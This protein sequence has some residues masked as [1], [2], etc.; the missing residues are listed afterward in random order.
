M[1]KLSEELVCIKKK[2]NYII[3]W[4]STWKCNRTRK[5]IKCYIAGTIL[6]QTI[7]LSK[8]ILILFGHFSNSVQAQ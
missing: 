7:T 3:D 8:Y 4:L 2:K 5:N 6:S 1:L